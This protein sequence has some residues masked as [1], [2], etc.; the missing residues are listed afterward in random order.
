MGRVN[1]RGSWV[2]SKTHYRLLVHTVHDDSIEGVLTIVAADGLILEGAELHR[3]DGG[4]VPLA[5]PT[6]IPKENV[7]LIQTAPPKVTAVPAP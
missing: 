7:R 3:S 4:R 1:L 6:F 2:K 5:G